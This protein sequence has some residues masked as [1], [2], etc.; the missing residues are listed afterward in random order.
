MKMEDIYL[1]KKKAESWFEKVKSLIDTKLILSL[2]RILRTHIL[3][4]LNKMIS[5]QQLKTLHLGKFL[6]V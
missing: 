5:V 1:C 6:K 2:K 3:C 4:L